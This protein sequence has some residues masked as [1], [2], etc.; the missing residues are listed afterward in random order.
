MT[1]ETQNVKVQSGQVEPHRG[2]RELMPL[3]D[4]YQTED[5]T[6]VIL[7]EL[8]GAAEDSIDVRVEKGVLTLSA[9]ADFGQGRFGENYSRTYTDFLGGRYFR[10]FALSDE[11][12]REK[13]EANFSDGVLQLTLPHAAA[14][15]VRKIQIQSK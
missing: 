14:A 2:E 13:I 12:D 11:I 7:A 10:A 9:E 6:G 15:E 8:P 4:I 5:G 1:Q 3:V